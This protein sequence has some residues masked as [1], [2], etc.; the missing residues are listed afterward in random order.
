MKRGTITLPI[1]QI[2]GKVPESNDMLIIFVKLGAIAEAESFEV[3]ER[4]GSQGS[5][6]LMSFDV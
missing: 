3:F 4:P 2:S 5:T 1:F 6:M